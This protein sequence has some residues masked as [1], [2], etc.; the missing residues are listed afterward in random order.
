[1]AEL[2]PIENNEMILRSDIPDLKFAD[3]RAALLDFTLDSTG[4]PG[5]AGQIVQFFAYPDQGNLKLLAVLRNEKLYVAG[6]DAPAKFASLTAESEK[7]NLFEY[8][9]KWTSFISTDI[10][11][12]FL[13]GLFIFTVF[14][15]SIHNVVFPIPDF[16]GTI[17]IVAG[18]IPFFSEKRLSK[19]VCVLKGSCMV[20]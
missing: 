1:M 3:F 9:N 20:L 7:F 15:I 4:E 11:K 16:P 18:M 2:L 6:C 13:S 12:T 17:V 5:Q 19:T 14:K 8:L 10:N